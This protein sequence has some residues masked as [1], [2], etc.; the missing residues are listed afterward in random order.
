MADTSTTTR[1][2]TSQPFLQGNG[3][4]IG[5]LQFSFRPGAEPADIISRLGQLW[6]SAIVGDD[7]P[8]VDGVY[9]RA[10]AP[11]YGAASG[12]IVVGFRPEFWAVIDPGGVPA[13]LHG[14]TADLE[15][16]NGSRAP[17]TQRDL[18]IWVNQSS[19]DR[20]YDSI[21]KIGLVL[22]E[23]AELAEVRECFTYH[24]SL[25]LDGFADGIGNPNVFRAPS[26]SVIP[27]GRPGAGGTTVLV[28]KWLMEVERMRALTPP[29]GETVYGR[30]KLK[31]HKL[32]PLPPR[33]HIARNQFHAARGGT[34]DIVRR[35]AY[36]GDAREAGVMFVG[37]S[38]DIDVTFGMLRQMYGVGPDGSQD[39]DAL[40]DYSRAV[41]GAIYFV[42]SY[43]ALQRAGV[44]VSD[45]P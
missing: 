28:Q 36:F 42:P 13:N 30:S 23:H 37:F 12:S 35:N 33:S 4:A 26:V 3:E 14:F 45:Q 18:W 15:G 24:N 34:I 41:S 31:G 10:A 2:T 40:L 27:A 9:G 39:L 1:A 8:S 32:S 5:H 22:A 16:R 6:G 11:E 17:A 20:L 7:D 25:T 38:D 43:D 29:Q 44:K 21:R 19:V